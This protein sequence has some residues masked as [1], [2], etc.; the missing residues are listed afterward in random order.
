MPNML[1]TDRDAGLRRGFH[2]GLFVILGASDLNRPAPSSNLMTPVEFISGMPL[3][4]VS[5]FD[6]DLDKKS[7]R[8]PISSSMNALTW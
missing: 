6:S 7:S 4:S 5:E 3:Q 2:P 8:L 1:R